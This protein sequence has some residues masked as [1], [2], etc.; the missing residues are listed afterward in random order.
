MSVQILNRYTLAVLYT[1]ECADL[2]G[3][4]LS[5][6]NL[7][8]ASL[9]GANLRGANLRGANLSGADLSGANLRYADLIGA[10]LRYADL[11]G[12]DCLTA[13]GD[14][15]R[16]RG[17][18]L[19]DADLSGADLRGANLR[20]ADLSGADLSGA[21]L[22]Y[23]DLSGADCLTAYGDLLRIAG[24]RHALIAVDE[25]NVSIGCL[26]HS[27]AWWCEHYAAVGSRES[28]TAQQIEEYRM[29]L[30]YA[31]QWLAFRKASKT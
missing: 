16:L 26:R 25:D 18:D 15:L 10:D 29:H 11:S 17:A 3:A 22:R 31:A 13:Y 21:N 9:S 14:L 2:I 27:L 4:N 5:D 1:S 24:S 12:A 23:A 19:S 28:Y 20:G 30:E 7:S 8:D 6:V